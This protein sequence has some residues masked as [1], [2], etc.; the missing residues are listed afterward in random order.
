L[1]LHISIRLIG[2][3]DLNNRLLFIAFF[4]GACGFIYGFARHRLPKGYALAAILFLAGIPAR[5]YGTE[6]RVYP[7]LLCAAAGMMYFWQAIPLTERRVVPLAG[8]WISF[9][10]AALL[11]IYALFL[12]V[13]FAAA[14]ISRSGFSWNKADKPVWYVLFTAPLSL[15]LLVPSMLKARARYGHGFSG[16]PNWASFGNSYYDV[17]G[18]PG[19]CLIVCLIAF[20]IVLRSRWAVGN[21]QKRENQKQGFEKPEWVL[22]CGMLALPA[23]G[24]MG[25]FVLGPFFPRYVLS[26]ILGMAL[27]L[28]GLVAMLCHRDS[29]AG[30]LLAGLLTIYMLIAQHH[31]FAML[32]AG[33]FGPHL[34]DNTQKQPWVQAICQSEL[35]VL[36]ASPFEYSVYQHYAPPC[37]RSKLTYATDIKK[38][39]SDKAMLS[40]DQT[41][42]WF[43][44]ILPMHVVPLSTFLATHHRFLVFT[45]SDPDSPYAGWLIPEMKRGDDSLRIL[46]TTRYPSLVGPVTVYEVQHN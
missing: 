46:S 5:A 36:G 44:K 11:H 19:L 21:E 31:T 15:L 13:P 10:F 16:T 26:V 28:I 29:R 18:I 45:K 14:E 1:F 43:P 41:M 24:I 2:D 6:M 3:S 17:L 40:G 12:F 4:L 39:E 9:A 25:A 42:I 38:A 35:S 8:L 27:S 23:I 7:L 34:I 20:A 30:Y 32:Y 37:M 33:N 22:V